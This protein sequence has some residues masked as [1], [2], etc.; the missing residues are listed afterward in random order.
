[1]ASFHTIEP[2]STEDSTWGIKIF[3]KSDRKTEEF[4]S[5]LPV[6]LGTKQH[7]LELLRERD[8]DIYQDLTSID[9]P[10]M[11]IENVPKK[12]LNGAMGQVYIVKANDEKVVF[13]LQ[14]RHG[15]TC[16]EG[17]NFFPRRLEGLVNTDEKTV[18]IGKVSEAWALYSFEKSYEMAKK[19][20]ALEIS[21]NYTK[22]YGIVFVREF[23]LWGVIYEYIDGKPLSTY[24]NDVDKIQRRMQSLA[25]GLKS[26]D[27][28]GYPQTDLENNVLILKSDDRTAVLF[29][30]I[31]ADK[32]SPSSPEI[33]LRSKEK[34]G[35]IF[36]R[37]LAR[38]GIGV[39]IGPEGRTSTITKK[40][41]EIFATYHFWG[42][43]IYKCDIDPSGVTW[44]EIITTLGTIPVGLE[45]IIRAR[46]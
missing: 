42:E 3:E 24:C 26:L 37:I 8:T 45:E 25:E 39:S 32:S 18:F 35:H 17:G 14:R 38:E 40:A 43:L 28:Q 19:H 4:S 20:R 11:E 6:D 34:F 27:R 44:D 12:L 31:T 10:M 41:K 1:M 29:D 36:Y 22:C 5:L 16:R 23:N 46:K 33:A 21:V 30:D 15:S 7:F 13:K 2:G 9:M